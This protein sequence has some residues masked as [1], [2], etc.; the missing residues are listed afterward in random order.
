MPP[1]PSHPPPHLRSLAMGIEKRLEDAG[2]RT[3]YA[4][5]YSDWRDLCRDALS[6]IYTLK[7][8]LKKAEDALAATPSAPV[9]GV[10]ST[11]IKAMSADVESRRVL[12]L[13]FDHEVTDR[14]R[15]NVIDAINALTREKRAAPSQPD[16]IRQA[17]EAEREACA[18]WHDEQARLFD[19]EAELR[20][21]LD[22]SPARRD[23][24]WARNDAADHRRFAAAIRARSSTLQPGGGDGE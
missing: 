13:H 17:V 3:G 7:G 5:E 1:S 2:R 10:N 14:D 8:K 18:A 22:G 9:S 11:G 6:A 4:E 19:R 21:D 15:Q 12:K 23:S 16:A 24:A 20:I